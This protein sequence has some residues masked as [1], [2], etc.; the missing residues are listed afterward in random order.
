MGVESIIKV[1]ITVIIWR[2]SCS[3]QKFIIEDWLLPS[4]SEITFLTNILDLRLSSKIENF[5][6]LKFGY[7]VQ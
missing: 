6:F 4:V 2:E 3:P 1:G 5:Q 7:W